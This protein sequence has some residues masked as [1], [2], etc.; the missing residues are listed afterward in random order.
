MRRISR[1]CLFILAN[2]IVALLLGCNADATPPRSSA[3]FGITPPYLAADL[4]RVA[5]TRITAPIAT[6][7]PQVFVPPIV[8]PPTPLASAAITR[9]PGTPLATSNPIPPQPTMTPRVISAEELNGYKNSLG[10]YAFNHPST[11]KGVEIK[12]DAYFDVLGKGRLEILV[13]PLE[14]GETLKALLEDSGPLRPPS[15]KN[16]DAMIAGEP[17]LQQDILDANNVVAARTYRVLHGGYVYYLTL[18]LP[19]MSV[20]VSPSK[21]LSDFEQLIASFQFLH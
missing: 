21:T 10:G 5:I 6:S 14:P 1:L 19:E 8:T 16:T 18:F 13:R 15:S 20:P 2:C 7:T 9:E 3:S 4:T 17:A 12:T 11:W